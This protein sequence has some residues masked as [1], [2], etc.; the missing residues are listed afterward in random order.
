M[1]QLLALSL[2]VASLPLFAAVPL[3][4]ALEL[5][6][7]E[8]NALRRLTCYDG[9]SADTATAAPATIAQQKTATAIQQKAA[10]TPQQSATIARCLCRC[11]IAVICSNRTIRAQK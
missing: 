1:K 11:G 7:A 4:Q 8:Q 2:V 9:I 3:E 5:C 6:R 10:A